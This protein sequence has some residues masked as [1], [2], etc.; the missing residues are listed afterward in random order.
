MQPLLPSEHVSGPLVE[1][2]ATLIEDSLALGASA[3][4]LAPALRPLLR[5]MNSYYTNQIEGQHTR[6]SDIARAL[7]KRFDAD[8]DLARRQRLAIAHIEAEVELEPLF[9]QMTGPER[10]DH[11]AVCRVHAAM[12]RRLPAHDRRTDLG[13]TIEPGALRTLD[14]AAGQHTAPPHAVVPALL[15]QWGVRYGALPGREQSIVG[16]VCAHH[17]LLWIHPFPDGNGR[18][19]RLH[20]H[21]VLSS[22][23][24]LRGLWS[25]LRGIARDRTRYYARLNNADLPRRNDL[26]G[27]GALSEE[28]LV[29][30]AQWLLE[31]CV[32]QCRF[33]RELL[34]LE[35]LRARLRDLLVA[36]AANPWTLGT[37]RSVIKLEALE[38][39]HYIALT[40]PLER[41]RFL[42][43][44]GL[45]PRTARRVLASLLD[46]GV[47][48]ET[49]PRS[50]VAFGVP[51]VALRH[52]FPR[53][54]PEAETELAHA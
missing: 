7:E 46:V 27:R 10:Y 45:P 28:E 22:L 16:A 49:S 1:L 50:P 38:A 37:E 26:D 9:L 35:G 25:P 39:L 52:V 8:S 42:A 2:A 23:G 41:G 40:G 3:G 17:R 47:L 24:L 21:L 15:D 32:D 36:L 44:T 33:M 31:L 51:L 30:F 13:A 20:L 11:R 48:T 34:A 4:S 18:A 53:L 12:Y 29:R 14:V 6:P 54:W 19:A 43:M 5:A